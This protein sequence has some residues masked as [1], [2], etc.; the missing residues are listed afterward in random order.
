MTEA[1]AFSLLNIVHTG[2]VT[3]L[4]SYV[5]G[6]ESSAYIHSVVCLTTGPWSLSNRLLHRV[7]SSAS[8]F[9]FQYPFVSLR[10]LRLLPRLSLLSSLFPSITCFRRQFLLKMRPTQLVFLLF[11][12]CRIFLSSLTLRNTSSFS[13]DRSN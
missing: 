2:C 3:L 4:T 9:N 12:V 11:I 1:R 8:S 7:R 13:H 10:C 6:T 5:L